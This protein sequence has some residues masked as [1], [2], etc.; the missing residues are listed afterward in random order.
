MANEMPRR[1]APIGEAF[2]TLSGWEHFLERLFGSI[3]GSADIC[4]TAIAPLTHRLT[5]SG[6][7]GGRCG[8]AAQ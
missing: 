4:A 7:F 8:V 6:W 1:F 3:T 5:R 2:I